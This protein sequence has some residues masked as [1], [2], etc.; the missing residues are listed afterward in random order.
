MDDAQFQHVQELGLHFQRQGF[1]ILK[2][3]S[4]VVGQLEFARASAGTIVGDPFLKAQ[5]LDNRQF[6]WHRGAA[7]NQERTITARA[8]IVQGPGEVV[9]AC[10]ALP[11]E[12]DAGAGGRRRFG[13]IAH[14][15][16]RFRPPGKIVDAHRHL[17]SRLMVDKLPD[18][19]SF[20]QGEDHPLR[21]VGAPD[22]IEAGHAVYRLLAYAKIGLNTCDR[23]LCLERFLEHV[24]EADIIR[25]GPAHERRRGHSDDPVGRSVGVQQD[26]L[27]VPHHDP[28]LD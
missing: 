6:V 14:P 22:E 16:D 11:A 7:E 23:S 21:P 27:V 17:W 19:L 15:L 9:L 26:A 4:A 2:E 1:D 20:G 12:Q 5:E 8:G 24:W 25:Q 28:L 13:Q 3:E 10:A 18:L